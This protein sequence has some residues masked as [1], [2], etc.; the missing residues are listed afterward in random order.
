M[1]KINPILG[2]PSTEPSEMTTAQIVDIDT[3]CKNIQ[4]NVRLTIPKLKIML[5]QIEENIYINY[6]TFVT[7]ELEDEYLAIT[8]TEYVAPVEYQE[9]TETTEEV[10]AVE[11]VL[12]G[13]E[14]E[15]KN[16]FIE[17][18]TKEVDYTQEYDLHP[19]IKLLYITPEETDLIIRFSVAT[20][21]MLDVIELLPNDMFN[22]IERLG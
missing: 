20:R 9:A 22:A 5:K 15:N 18:L 14:L 2:L 12:A 13:T 17:S 11:E 10:L 4:T 21:E 6:I 7:Q 3:I 19:N 16:R 8:E 1:Q